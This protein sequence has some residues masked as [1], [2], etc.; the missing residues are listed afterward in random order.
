MYEIFIIIFNFY[1]Y[2]IYNKKYPK[3]DKLTLK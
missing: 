2:F 1:N 3:D